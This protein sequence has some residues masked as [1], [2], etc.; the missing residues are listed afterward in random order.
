MPGLL[1][2]LFKIGAMRVAESIRIHI[3]WYDRNMT[4]LLL[5]LIKDIDRGMQ[6]MLH[7]RLLPSSDRWKLVGTSNGRGVLQ[8]SD[9]FRSIARR[10]RDHEAGLLEE[11]FKIGAMRV[12]ESIRIHT[13]N[14]A[15]RSNQGGFTQWLTVLLMTIT[16]PTS[17]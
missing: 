4:V 3:V 9:F 11:L 7:R 13:G 17:M 14:G 6:R 5:D 2:E 15:V 16:L 8:G 12:A 1:K 10:V